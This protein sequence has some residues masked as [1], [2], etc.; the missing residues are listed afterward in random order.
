MHGVLYTC[1]LKS[2]HLYSPKTEHISRKLLY[3]RLNFSHEMNVKMFR[4]HEKGKVYLGRVLFARVRLAYI[5]KCT[6]RSYTYISRAE[7]AAQNSEPS[8]KFLYGNGHV[9]IS[10]PISCFFF[11]RFHIVILSCALILKCTKCIK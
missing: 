11:T 1:S 9:D 5:D 6:N 2:H 8:S 4:E 10:P 3:L 7:S